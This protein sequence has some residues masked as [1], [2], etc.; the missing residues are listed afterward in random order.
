MNI[1]IQRSKALTGE[2]NVPGDKSI[3]HRAVMLGSI[4]Q[5]T[6]LIKDFSSGEDCWKTVNAMRAL[7]VRIG[8]EDD[9]FAVHGMGLN[10]LTEPWEQLDA[11]NSGTMIR[12]L[13]GI[14][15]GQSFESTIAGDQYLNAR[16]MRRIIE[17]LRLMGAEISGVN[18]EYPPLRIKGGNLKP[19]AYEMPIQS[20]QVKSCVL[21]AG[22]YTDG[23][24]SVIEKSQT[25][26][27]TERMLKAFGAKIDKVKLP[28]GG[29]ETSLEGRPDLIGTELIVPVDISAA[30]FFIVAATLVPRS[31]LLIKNV[32]LNPTRRGIIDVLGRMG[33]HI[34][35]ENERTLNGEPI[36]DLVIK[37]ANLRG[38][39]VAG[40]LI[41]N[42]IDEIPILAIAGSQAEGETL[43]RDAEELR[44]KETDRIRAVVENLRRMGVKVGELSDGMIIEGGQP[45]VGTEIE[46][47][48]D[49][50][51]AMAFA[52]AGLIAKGETVIKNAEWVDTSFPGF[53]EKI[54]QLKGW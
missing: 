18:D 46:S 47:Y 29:F 19:I 13:S 6:T 52:V 20:A 2:F 11:G 31:N 40:S 51:I 16:P 44:K 12:L 25:R 28:G 4:A 36:G 22:L 30:A 24:T 26:D 15:A 8:Q 42:I 14:L 32:G 53:F 7:G 33:A 27:H 23:W 49:H 35:V 9:H 37:S 10:G 41:P 1:T 34:S 50:R 45:L 5:G 21:L 54:G 38:V 3:S 43:I 48:G 39:K 17:P